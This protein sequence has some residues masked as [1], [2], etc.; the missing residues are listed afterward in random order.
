MKENQIES[1]QSCLLLKI[2]EWHE[3]RFTRWFNQQKAWRGILKI[4]AAT[5]A[6]YKIILL[7]P[8]PKHH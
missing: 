2:Y 6:K 1:C 7:W 4:G 8:N 3:K 5:A